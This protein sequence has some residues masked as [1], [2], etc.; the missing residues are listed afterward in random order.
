MG[1][2]VSVLNEPRQSASPRHRFDQFNFSHEIQGVGFSLSVEV[3]R[4]P[5]GTPPEPPEPE[6]WK[7]G[8]IQ[9]VMRERIL[10]VYESGRRVPPVNNSEILSSPILDTM[11]HPELLIPED[12]QEPWIYP[13]E[14]MRSDRRELNGFQRF[15]YGAGQGPDALR[16]TMEDYPRAAFY[17][18]FRGGRG[19]DQLRQAEDRITF[20]IWVVAKRDL[21]PIHDRGSYHV[22]AFSQPFAFITTL[23]IAGHNAGWA[24][25]NPIPAQ[26]YTWRVTP[27]QTLTPTRPTVTPGAAPLGLVSGPTANR[28]LPQIFAETGVG[29]ARSH[30][31]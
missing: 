17:N 7:V 25:A 22:L 19:G 13:K 12:W 23:N 5:G 4:R 27:H 14:T 16:L 1:L 10:A 15:T 30:Q 11:D 21:D 6:F 28:A 3:N 8:F 18:V 24:P 26:G 2:F 29:P 31:W 20:R 9:N